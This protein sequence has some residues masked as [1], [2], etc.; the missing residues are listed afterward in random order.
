MIW[1]LS[2]I[3]KIIRERNY[4]QQSFF[5]YRAFC[6]SIFLLNSLVAE[7][8]KSLYNFYL[9]IRNADFLPRDPLNIVD[10]FGL[11]LGII[12]EIRSRIDALSAFSVVVATTVLNFKN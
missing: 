9:M 8:I 6:G 12:S 10:V 4:V 11:F 7:K 5:I 1:T 2:K 3:F